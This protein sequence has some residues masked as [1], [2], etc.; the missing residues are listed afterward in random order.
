MKEE[1][2]YKVC[3][4]G[5]SGVGK[6]TLARRY[7]TGYFEENIKLTLGAEIFFKFIEIENI[8][9]ALQIWDF[10]GEKEFDFL[11]PLYSRGASGGIFMFDLSR[12]QT[13]NRTENWL[14][15][16]REG[17]ASDI[18][19]VPTLLVG[20]K[21]DLQTQIEISNKEVKN[22]AREY[23]LFNDIECSSKTGQNVENVFETLVKAILKTSFQTN[24]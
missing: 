20:G 1:R 2:A 22:V 24:K 10:G 6:T 18:K 19:K 14:K 9:V 5:E 4:F 16:F 7:L 15:F 21:L 3:I 23:D 13:L 11:L 8:R 17:L 12:K